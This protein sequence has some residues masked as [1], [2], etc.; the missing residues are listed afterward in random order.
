MGEHRALKRASRIT[1]DIAKARMNLIYGQ[2]RIE[3][4]L[5]LQYVVAN[6]PDYIQNFLR[7]IVSNILVILTKRDVM[8]YP[9]S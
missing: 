1:S 9:T 5:F 6:P 3:D 7:H 4:S 8:Y 2:D